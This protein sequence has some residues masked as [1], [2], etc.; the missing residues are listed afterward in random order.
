M[1][2]SNGGPGKCKR[3]RPRTT[4]WSEST[5]FPTTGRQWMKRTWWGCWRAFM[6]VEGRRGRGQQKQSDER[7]RWHGRPGVRLET[8]ETFERVC[9]QGED[10]AGNTTEVWQG[11]EKHLLV[12]GS[13]GVPVL[14]VCFK[15]KRQGN[16]TPT[17]INTR[18]T[19]VVLFLWFIRSPLLLSAPVY[20]CKL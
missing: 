20:Y 5:S 12:S 16:G 19:I 6:S 8:E 1:K 13:T 11:R 4:T 18:N 9:C 17:F 3:K 2:R 10:E 15:K 7:Y 14:H